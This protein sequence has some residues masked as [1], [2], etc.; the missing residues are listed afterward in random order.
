MRNVAPTRALAR[1]KFQWLLVAFFVITGGV[2]AAI[3][4]IAMTALP[5]T[6]P[7]SSS[8][9]TYMTTARALFLFGVVV[10]VFGVGVA[11]RGATWREENDLARIVG[12]ALAAF[13]DERYTY[14]R[15][16][17]KVDFPRRAFYIDAVMVGTQGVL[18]FR[19]LDRSGI[20]LNEHDRWLKMNPATNQWQP[21]GI[22]ATR[23][24]QADIT[25]LRDYLRQR[26]LPAETPIF[27][28]VVFLKDAP[29]VQLS[30]RQPALPSTS[31][32]GL[33]AALQDNYFAQERISRG[34]ADAIVRLLHD[35]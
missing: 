33:Y 7:T 1:R 16:V 8:Y 14:I 27:G 4:G 19:I 11:I 30:Q 6:A 21:A 25:H 31:L 20:F 18:V 26:G 3:V 17:S 35:V 23:Q 32:S 28:V 9:N 13:L 10:S 12:K 5:L 22:D 2:L 34:A 24:A 29:M 15:N